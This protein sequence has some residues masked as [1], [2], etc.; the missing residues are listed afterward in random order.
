LTLACQSLEHRL[1][2][3][4]LN[5]SDQFE[6]LTR[7]GDNQHAEA[8]TSR[9][10]PPLEVPSRRSGRER[11]KTEKA[12]ANDAQGL[13]SYGT[14]RAVVA[15]RV[16][17]AYL[18]S[19]A[20][21]SCDSLPLAKDTVIP[22]TYTQAMA[23]PQADFWIAAMQSEVNSHVTNN[24]WDL[25]NPMDHPNVT[26]VAGRW[27]Y[28][29][30]ANSEGLPV[31]F[32]ARWVARGF[33]QRYG[34]D[35]DD[36]Y[37]SV[38]KPATVK[39]MLALVAK[40]DMECKQYDL[41]T[42]FLNVL[43]KD[44]KIFVEMPHGFEQ[45]KGKVQ[46]ICLLK[47]ALY[48]LKQSPLL[49]YE[50]LSKFLYSMDLKPCISDPCLFLHPS[51]AYILVYVDDLLLMAKSLELINRLAFLLGARYAMKE[52]GDVAWF[53]GCH[54]IR[55][56]EARKIWIVQSAYVSTMAE[57]FG[58]EPRKHSTPMK[59]GT[60]LI[61]APTSFSATK[62]S[63]KQYQELVGSMMWP[64]TITRGDIAATVSKLAMYLTNPTAEH[65]EA[66]LHCAEYL[67]TTKN[68]GICLGGDEL[69]L[70][71]F[72]DASWAD[73]S[74]DRRSTCG[75]VFKFGGGPVFWK[76]GRQSVV[77]TSTTE[78]EYV[79]M[80]LAARE[81]A[82]LR[83]LVTEVLQ[84]QHPAIILYEDNKPAIH[85]LNKPPGADTKTKHMDVKYHFIRQEVGRGAITV[86]KIPTDKQAAD[87]LTKSLNRIKHE[88]FK[89]LFGIVDCSETI[90]TRVTQD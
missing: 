38:T 77:A 81:A 66:A 40:L 16:H 65:H 80:S 6:S 48:G 88:Q 24:T 1:R 10:L 62:Q 79:A 60:E 25:V 73:N 33:T 21:K 86:I 67:L 32:K 57:R 9:T 19:V 87:G 56:R 74:D 68:D 78:A 42:A 53:L 36:T 55:D 76:S 59:A 39:I 30:K 82:A 37:A 69:Q 84:E 44:H 51:G 41:V 49:W 11:T 58:I 90:A 31:R 54:I 27:V 5:L 2:R 43:I 17:K 20:F 61:K 85:L 14:K 47:R 35:Y 12:L 13:N 18:T 75:Y 15:Q 46:M 70:E 45:Y 83:R 28:T 89:H 8:P 23:S 52:L 29:I 50:E 64:A 3:S 71:G 34:I 7:S 72:V 63:K 26:I 4:Y 22:N